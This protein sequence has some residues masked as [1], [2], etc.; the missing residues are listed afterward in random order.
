MVVMID[1][2][3]IG[4]DN[5]DNS[6][7][8]G[9]SD[10]NNGDGQMVGVLEIEAVLVVNAMVVTM[11]DGDNNDNIHSGSSNGDDGCSNDNIVGG[12]YGST[13]G[14]GKCWW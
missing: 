2:L 1:A 9:G 10:S 4:D 3:A 6:I 11:V 5:S 14:G 12:G 13:H 7:D 8:S